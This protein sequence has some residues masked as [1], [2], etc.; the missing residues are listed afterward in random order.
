MK[1]VRALSWILCAPLVL[2]PL[3]TTSVSFAQQPAE[4][5]VQEEG[6]G[7][8]AEDSASEVPVSEEEMATA[9]LHFANGVELLQ[10][11][12][13]NYQDAY[14]QLQLALEKSG[15][16]WKV[17]G[18]LAFCALK[19]E[20]DGEALEYYEEYLRRGGD[21]IDPREKASIE[22]ETLL[23][24]GNLATVVIESSKP[25]VRI[26]V[27]RQGSTAPVQV[28]QLEEGRTE[29][30]LRS[31][32]LTIT[33]EADGKKLE[34][35]PVLAA[36]ESA[37]HTFDFSAPSR[38]ASDPVDSNSTPPDPTR[39]EPN[40]SGMSPLRLSGIIAAGV[41]VVALGGGVALGVVSQN[42]EKAAQDECI[43]NT[44]LEATESKFDSAKSMATA[45]NILFISGGVLAA[46][47]V[48]LVIIGGKK[49][50]GET[51]QLPPH[52]ARPHGALSHRALSHLALSPLALPGGGGVFA[53][54]RF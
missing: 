23:A 54:G 51:V 5:S 11:E 24:R 26:R 7:G 3:T 39:D 46:T 12:P 30:G 18:N 25:S 40:S 13:P 19:L 15:R 31:G 44:C 53:Q 17:L 29:L 43:D 32:T 35:N 41:G 10:A 52:T 22:K 28:Y 47:G 27:Q 34:W 8:Q 20:R 6:A 38:G 1:F 21:A 16:S 33:A 37:S 36:G 50:S 45:A 49:S 42:K 9:R 2:L 14:Q 48:T 4:G